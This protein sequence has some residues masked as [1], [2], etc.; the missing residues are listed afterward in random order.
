MTRLVAVDTEYD[1]RTLVP[2]CLTW[3]DQPGTGHII[4]ATDAPALAQFNAANA[5]ATYIF[6]N[7]KADLPMLQKMGITVNRWTD[8]MV[9]AYHL[10]YP[11]ALKI[12]AYRLCGMSMREYSAM[13][14]PE[15]RDKF[16]YWLIDAVCLCY[17][18]PPV[19]EVWVNEGP[20]MEW[21]TKEVARPCTVRK[22]GCERCDCHDNP[23]CPVCLGKGYFYRETKR[24]DR[25]PIPGTEDGYWHVKQPQ[26]PVAGLKRLLL[27]AMGDSESDP[28]G[29]WDN[30]DESRQD[31]VI[32]I[33]GP[34]PVVTL[35]D[36]DYDQAVWYACRDADATLRVYHV[37]QPLLEQYGLVEATALDCELTPYV[38]AMEA[39]GM[40]IDPAHFAAMEADYTQRLA[41]VEDEI[42]QALGRRF[43]PGSNAAV[44]K[45]LYDELKLSVPAHTKKG[46]PAV[47]VKA[48][49]KLESEHI[50]VGLIKRWREISKYLS[51]YI[52]PLPACADIDSR[53]H[54]TVNQTRTETG[55]LSV[56]KPNLQNQPA[57]GKDAHTYREGFVAQPGYEMVSG[58]YSN[59]ELRV[60]AHV[61][62]DPLLLKAFREDLDLH[63]LTASKVFNVAEADVTSLMRSAAKMVNFGV[64]YGVTGPSL[65][66]QFNAQKGVELDQR[67]TPERGQE[68]IDL[69]FGVYD[70]VHAYMQRVHSE[71]K[72]QGYVREPFI[73]HIRWVPGIRSALGYIRERSL[74]EAGN[75][76]VQGGAQV[77]I[78]QAMRKLWTS[79]LLEQHGAIPV[80][81]VHDAL[82]F[83]V[84]VDSVE[85]FIADVKQLME[86]AVRLSVPINVDFKHGPTWADCK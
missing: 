21:E 45:L 56:N 12:L 48:L 16:I 69:W 61:S 24:G 15:R 38:L 17:P 71:T 86:T 57:R 54:P 5:D 3:S 4:M 72:L 65:A 36:V 66:E 29:A 74:R 13:V 19:E 26:N 33:A 1:P 46:D 8:T 68:I 31:S 22:R 6:H 79:G 14:R 43:N 32:A 85:S 23:H 83:E 42:A 75:V 64:V 81:Q 30:W 58:D 70:C 73:G 47:D 40:R 11:Q 53:V 50:V 37:L 9:M 25:I 59:I 39:N 77:L 10:G 62:Q 84:P 35:A 55:R 60:L 27:N 44:A 67:I 80:M 41:D 51:T 63:R 20:Q 78:K 28:G 52:K 2:W 18:D 76:P 82:D 34:P 7:A 49:N